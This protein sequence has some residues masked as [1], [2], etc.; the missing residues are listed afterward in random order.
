MS[1]VMF[2]GGQVSLRVL[3]VHEDHIRAAVTGEGGRHRVAPDR[4]EAQRVDLF[5][6]LRILRGSGRLRRGG[7]CRQGWR[8]S[9]GGGQ[10]GRHGCG[11]FLLLDG[12][13]GNHGR[14]VGGRVRDLGLA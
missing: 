4:N 3:L 14:G 9:L 10:V 7:F 5:V 8:S 6:V 13:G 2:L 11:S 1:Q 12:R